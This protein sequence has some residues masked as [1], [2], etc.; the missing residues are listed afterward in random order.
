VVSVIENYLNY[1]SL[2]CPDA[3][4]R[5]DELANLLPPWT[6][7]FPSVGRRFYLNTISK[8]STFEKPT[9]VRSV[10]LLPDGRRAK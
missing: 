9:F 3:K 8:E 1:I 4:F 7:C 2:M 10:R 6:L 5:E